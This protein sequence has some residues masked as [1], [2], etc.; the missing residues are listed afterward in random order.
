MKL[1]VQISQ[2]IKLKRFQYIPN[3]Y[4]NLQAKVAGT[5]WTQKG[6]KDHI[7]CLFAICTID[8]NPKRS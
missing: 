4:P 5:D 8:H 1:V 2:K 6:Y 3:V 7:A